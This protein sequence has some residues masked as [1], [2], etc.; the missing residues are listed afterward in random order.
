[1]TGVQTVQR[2]QQF[3]ISTILPKI[4]W[5][6]CC[7]LEARSAASLGIARTVL[8]AGLI[9]I[10]ADAL[11]LAQEEAVPRFGTTNYFIRPFSGSLS[12]FSAAP[13][14]WVGDSP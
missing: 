9:G 4:W 3:A 2:A 10:A 5:C 1:M 7:S 13:F 8:A 14:S 6:R 12:G 11:A